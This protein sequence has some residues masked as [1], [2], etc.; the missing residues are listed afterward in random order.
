MGGNKP[1]VCLG[2]AHDAPVAVKFLNIEFKGSG[3]ENGSS[4]RLTYVR[5]SGDLITGW[6]RLQKVMEKG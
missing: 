3:R 5:Q 6:D 1:P 2:K 4:L